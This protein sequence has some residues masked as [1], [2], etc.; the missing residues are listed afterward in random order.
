MTCK[1]EK[2]YVHVDMHGI[3]GLNEVI[4]KVKD[5]LRRRIKFSMYLNKN[6]I[7]IDYDNP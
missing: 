1:Q 5:L 7:I 3:N 2:Y 6:E 4:N